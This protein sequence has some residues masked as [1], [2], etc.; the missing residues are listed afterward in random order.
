MPEAS[1]R[2]GQVAKML[3]LSS[4]QVRRLAETG[5]IDTE[6]SGKQWRVPAAEVDRLL[7][8]GIP[9]IPANGTRAENPTP[10]KP[11]NS[12]PS[13]GLLAP[14]SDVVVNAAEE[15]VVLE[16][17]VRSLALRRQKEEALDWFRARQREEEEERAA[18]ERIE[19]ARLAG[20]QARLEREEW[21]REWETCAVNAVPWDAPSEMRLEV[22]E[23]VRN[24]LASLNPIPSAA[25]TEQLVDAEV[26]LVVG[27]WRREQEIEAVLI[28]A[29]DRLLPYEARGSYGELSDWQVHAV[30][31]VAAAIGELPDDATIEEI[32]AAAKQAVA[33]VAAE[34]HESKAAQE[35]AQMR[36][37][38]IQWARLP[39]LS[40]DGR[41][42]ARTAI[43][44]A[45]AELPQGTPRHKLEQARDAVLSALNVAIAQRRQELANE[46]AR[47]QEERTRR[48]NEECRKRE[49]QHRQQRER[50][51]REIVISGSTWRLPFDFSS[52]EREQVTAAVRKAI[53]Q[54]P[55]GTPQRG[56]EQ[57]RDQVLQP[58]L[59]RAQFVQG[60][61]S[62]APIRSPRSC[63]THFGPPIRR[64]CRTGI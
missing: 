38:I 62:G 10:A 50:D 2:T 18:E 20:E 30:R 14:P 7:K 25:V 28:E 8:E 44:D 12:Q 32:R 48:Q 42:L 21:L 17:E 37:R 31:S 26:Q 15:V 46:A 54:A 9:E 34:F 64:R 59:T 36:E 19:R 51:T 58:F 53:E 33:R 55:E 24:R 4:Y 3:G 5:M 52:A 6:Y 22:H 27:R 29:R 16:N 47:E 1:Y 56:L 60:G 61:A 40:D 35:D 63:G 13:N 11:S 23:A 45:M 49:E 41:E 39:E 57:I 43:A